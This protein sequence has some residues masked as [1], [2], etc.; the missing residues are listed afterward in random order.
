MDESIE[1][2]GKRFDELKIKNT[3]QNRKKYRDLLLQTPD[4]QKYT[5]GCILHEE[6]A[7][8]GVLQH[9]RN[10]NILCGLKM[11]NGLIPFNDNEFLSVG[12]DKLESKCKKYG[13]LGITFAK[14][15]C[16]FHICTKKHLPST[17][18]IEENCRTLA[19]F[20]RICQKHNIVPIIEPEVLMNGNHTIYDT[21][22]TQQKILI[23]LFHV[24]QNHGVVLEHIILKTNMVLPGK[25][26]V[27]YPTQVANITIQ[28][29]ERS[30]PSA[31][32]VIAF[33][34]GGLSEDMASL[35]LKQIKKVKKKAK[36]YLTFSF[37]R[38]LQTSCMKE[39]SN[40]KKNVYN[41]QKELL[42]RLI[43]NTTR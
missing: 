29:L 8:K 31:V 13:P 36:W 4:L 35:Y 34:S 14:W 37:G 33:L 28:T 24:M 5:S 7:E 3:K 9:L 22:N 6:T 39:W 20:A 25:N 40:K 1:T 23:N 43:M 12:L 32:P 26:F 21:A 38:A 10:Q 16:V 42:K 17:S 41:A 11:D 30:V 2:I 19:E 27:S 18:C 15:R